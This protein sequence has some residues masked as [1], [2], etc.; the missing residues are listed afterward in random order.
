MSAFYQVCD[1]VIC[2]L[3]AKKAESVLTPQ[4]VLRRRVASPFTLVTMNSSSVLLM[5]C[6]VVVVCYQLW[7]AGSVC[8]YL[9]SKAVRFLIS[10]NAQ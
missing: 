5:F 1:K 6:F 3:S 7:L 9:F 4:L 10:S 2:G 8:H